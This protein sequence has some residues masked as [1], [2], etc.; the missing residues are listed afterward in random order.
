M[1]DRSPT[2]Q[3]PQTADP[4]ARLARFRTAVQGEDSPLPAAGLS[5]QEVVE[6]ASYGSL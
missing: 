1:H 6:A 4:C 5:A 3:L 2:Q